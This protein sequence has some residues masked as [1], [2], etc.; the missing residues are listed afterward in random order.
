MHDPVATIASVIVLVGLAMAIFKKWES[1]PQRRL[2]KILKRYEID[3]TI[4]TSPEGMDPTHEITVGKA[5]FEVRGLNDRN[6]RPIPCDWKSVKSVTAY[7]RD[8]FSTDLVC[9]AFELSDG[10]YIEVDEQMRGWLELC[11]ALPVYLPSAPPWGKWFMNITV[12]AFES[13]MTTLF[14]AADGET[15]G[16]TDD[17]SKA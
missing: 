2:A 9:M 5:G 17:D 15:V 10:T 14:T 13:C 8:M 1:T 16:S 4:E 11:N 6:D 7:K 3:S 12:P